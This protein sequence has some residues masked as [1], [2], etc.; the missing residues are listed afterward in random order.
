MPARSVHILPTA[1]IT[2]ASC[3]APAIAQEWA[4]S[5]TGDWCQ[6]SN[7]NP[8]IVPNAIGANAIIRSTNQGGPLATGGIIFINEPITIGALDLDM[9]FP[10]PVLTLFSQ[11][12]TFDNGSGADVFLDAS[13][14]NVVDITGD[15]I[16]MGDLISTWTA[17]EGTIFA[18][19]SGDH[20]I[21]HQPVGAGAKRLRL[22]GN[23]TYTGQT[24]IISGTLSIRAA[25]GLGASTAGTIVEADGILLAETIGN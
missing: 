3:A 9:G 21:I 12:I 7:W 23:N 10:G 25:S 5:M 20:A 24:R 18:D 15:I 4:A 14:A 1:I 13:G 16:L 11:S 19:I 22:F 8:A 2:A 17:S 6:P